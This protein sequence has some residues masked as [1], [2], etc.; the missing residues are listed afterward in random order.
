MIKTYTICLVTELFKFYGSCF[1][2]S[3]NYIMS[4]IDEVLFHN[5][6]SD[7]NLVSNH[8]SKKLASVR[9]EIFAN[10]ISQ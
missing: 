8:I 2:D 7:F 6:S 10:L 9:A 1:V 3:H 5:P 4:V